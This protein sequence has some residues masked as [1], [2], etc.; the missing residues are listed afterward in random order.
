MGLYS[1]TEDIDILRVAVALL[2]LGLAYA[3]VYAAAPIT[4]SWEVVV[5]DESYYVIEN[6]HGEVFGFLGYGVNRM[7]WHRN[8]LVRKYVDFNTVSIYEHFE[9][10]RWADGVE[11]YIEIKLTMDFNPV[12]AD[13]TMYMAMRRMTQQT[14]FEELIRRDLHDFVRHQSKLLAWDEL[15]FLVCG[16]KTIQGAIVDGLEPLAAIG[17]TP[18]EN[19]PIRVLVDAV[20]PAVEQ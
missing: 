5:P 8:A 3:G 2:A 19:H 7:G 13:P 18:S 17:L 14:T 11:G 15:V 20:S 1:I 16:S 9:G 10:I 6:Q 12:Q 4:L